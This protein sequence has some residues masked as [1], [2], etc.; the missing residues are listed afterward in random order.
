MRFL[1]IFI[2]IVGQVF[3]Q[4]ISSGGD[5]SL[6]VCKDGKVY[7]AG[8]N[9]DGQLGNGSLAS[10][11][12][13]QQVLGIDSIKSVQAG[14]WY[15]IALQNN[16]AVW[17]WGNNFSSQLGLGLNGPINAYVPTR[18][19]SIGP[20]TQISAGAFH[21]LYLLEDSTVWGTGNNQS[22][23]LGQIPPPYGHVRPGM[24]PGLND[25]IKIHA[26]NGFSLVLRSDSTV[27]SFGSNGWG[28]LGR[29]SV[30]ASASAPAQMDSLTSVIDITGGGYNS[31]ALTS[32]GKVWGLGRNDYGQLSNAIPQGQLD[33]TAKPVMISGVDSIVA[34][35]SLGTHV[36]ALK[37]DGTVWAWGAN[38][39]GHLGNGTTNKV[40]SP[41]KVIGLKGIVEV[42]AGVAGMAVDSAGQV[43]TWGY[44]PDGALGSDSIHQKLIATPISPVSCNPIISLSEP[45]MYASSIEV[46]P[47]PTNSAIYLKLQEGQNMESL[48]L[49]NSTGALV[50]KVNHAASMLD[51]SDLAPG[52]YVLA[53]KIDGELVMKKVVKE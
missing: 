53:I 6:M 22:G 13:F 9:I 51:V 14:G 7:A 23:E 47:N 4:R 18:M 48:E 33:F 3:G 1:A 43:Y 5:H 19:D 49:Y 17:V 8:N 35:S 31:F 20:V 15:S 2:L 24:V 52:M 38:G 25:V 26:G 32:D 27:W 39:Y 21:A 28:Y 41:T 46:Y 12:I 50:K 11:S 42:N 37:S 30:S 10:D 16:G 29:G 45:K 36:L 44:S 34:I 40:S